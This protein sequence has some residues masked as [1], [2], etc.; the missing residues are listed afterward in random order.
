MNRAGLEREDLQQKAL[1]REA[2]LVN[3]SELGMALTQLDNPAVKAMVV[4][5]S[6]PAAIAPRIVSALKIPFPQ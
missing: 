1:G 2:R 5:N 3:M 4:Y 6:N